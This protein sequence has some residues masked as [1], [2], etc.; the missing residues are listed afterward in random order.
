MPH[1][2]SNISI[3]S[4]RSVLLVEETEM[5][6]WKPPTYRKSPT[7]FITWCCIEYSSQWAVFELTKL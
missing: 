1:S 7:N 2:T 5:R 6:G 3:V 4:C